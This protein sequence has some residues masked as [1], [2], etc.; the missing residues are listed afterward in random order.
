M[1]AAPEPVLR[2]GDRI[3]FGGDER[4]VLG[5]AGTEVRLRSDGGGE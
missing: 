3:S 4:R 5:V 1:V 2:V